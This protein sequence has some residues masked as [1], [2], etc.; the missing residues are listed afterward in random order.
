MH[1]RDS[2]PARRMIRISVA[3]TLVAG[4]IVILLFALPDSWL[5]GIDWYLFLAFVSA[6]GLAIVLALVG[7][8]VRGANEIVVSAIG[9]IGLNL[10]V[11]LGVTMALFHFRMGAP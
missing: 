4:L 9:L 1:H 8:A 7:A 5:R 10:M 6:A 2:M 3:V 11:L